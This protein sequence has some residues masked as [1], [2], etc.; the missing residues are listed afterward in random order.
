MVVGPAAYWYGW[1]QGEGGKNSLS[2]QGFHTRGAHFCNLSCL[3]L[4]L[5]GDGGAQSWRRGLRG[6]GPQLVHDGAAV[7]TLGFSGAEVVLRESSSQSGPLL[8]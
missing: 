5:W 6:L 1:L 2:Y 3:G 7:R 8:G 4:G